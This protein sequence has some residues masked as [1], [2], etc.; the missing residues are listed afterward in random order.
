MNR[1]WHK[2]TM[3]YESALEKEGNSDVHTNMDEA[4]GHFAQ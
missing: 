2:P 3:G 4:G 1:V